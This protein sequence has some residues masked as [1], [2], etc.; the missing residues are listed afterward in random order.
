MTAAITAELRKA[1][2]AAYRRD[3]A[4]CMEDIGREA[5][6]AEYDRGEARTLALTLI[7]SVRRRRARA[8]GA[9]RLM[10]EFSP[11]TREGVALMCLAEALLRVPDAPTADRLIRDKIGYADWKSHLGNPSLFVNAATWGLMLGSKLLTADDRD[12]ERGVLGSTLGGILA[13]GGEPAVRVG[14]EFAARRL[15][16]QYVMAPTIEAA[17]V[18]AASAEARGYRYSFDVL[19]EAAM[20]AEE[21]ERYERDYAKAIE[22]VGRASRGRGVKLGPGIS[23]KLSAL[24]PRYTHRQ[25]ERVMAELLPRLVGLAR[26]AREHDVGISIDAEEADRLE[27]SLDLFAALAEE[28]SLS[29]WDGLGFVVQ[30]YQKRA[31][32]VVDWLIDLARRRKTRLM[33][34]LVKGAYWDSEIK[35][36][37]AD[38][39]SDFP[40]FTRKVHTDVV[41]LACAQR[42]LH[43]AEAVYPQFATHNAY[44]VAALAH[45]ARAARVE[46]Y[47]FQC[48]HGMGET[49][50]DEIVG[51]E[52][53]GKACRIYAPVGTHDTLLPYL[54]RRLLENGANNAFVRQLADASIPLDR[55][56]EDPLDTMR[57]EGEGPHPAILLPGQLYGPRRLNSEGVDLSDDP[58]IDRLGA[59]LM[60]L[61]AQRWIAEPLVAGMN[62]FGTEPG[63][64]GLAAGS[65]RVSQPVVNPA[66]RDD[67]V[68]RV[69]AATPEQADMAVTRAVE[70]A[71]TWWRTPVAERA[72]ALRRAADL[73]ERERDTL[74]S[75]CI[76]EAGKTWSNAI[77][78]VREAV[79]ACRY[80]AEQL[81]ES[82]DRPESTWAG[83]GEGVG[84][85]PQEGV[86]RSA[87]SGFA[88][89]EAPLPR[90]AARTVFD[91]LLTETHGSP[92]LAYPE[93]GRLP[94]GEPAPGPVVC[95]SPWNFPLAIF[96][97]QIAGALA[98]GRTVIAKPAG[99][100]PLVASFAVERLRE[101]GIPEV[102]LQF[103]PGSGASVGAPLIAD[104][105]VSGVLFTGST[106]VAR[107]IERTL[108]AR[109]GS[110]LI[111]E[112]GGQN[113]MIVDSTALPEQVVADVLASGFDSAGQRC[114]ALRV[115]CLQNDIA[116]RTLTMLRAA[117]RELA[118]GDPARLDTDVGPV[119]DAAA[120]AA[121]LAHVE[122]MRHR[123]KNVYEVDLPDACGA[124]CFVPP[125]LIEID[126]LA[127]LE[128]EVFGPIVHVLR[129]DAGRLDELI[130]AIN[131]TGYGLTLGIHSRIDETVRRISS[132]AHVGNVYVNR[133]MI[134]AVVGVQPFGGEGLSGTGPKAG[135]PLYVHRLLGS[136]NV[137]PADYGAVR[138]AD[139]LHGDTLFSRLTKWAFSSG[140]RDLVRYCTAY[141]ELTPFG[142]RVDL[143]GPTGERNT[144]TFAPRG[145][146]LCEASDAGRLLNALAAAFATGNEVAVPDNAVARSILANI[147]PRD[148]ASRIMVRTV[149]EAAGLAGVLC[150]DA[151][152]EAAW[153][154]RFA[155]E[156]GPLRPVYTPG[157]A[158][159]LY[160]LYRMMVE[161]VV[162]VNTTAS[163]GNT[164]LM[165]LGA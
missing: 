124:G 160:P 133:N 141:A 32:F 9:D 74:V 103:L 131:A 165:M 34:R 23:V 155:A 139:P 150:A 148:I 21:A 49:L 80:Y 113:A 30:A 123:G 6:A 121:L 138:E 91:E 19:G 68:G 90:N 145:R 97:A 38:G 162:S 72:A 33:V 130:D 149:E 15:A 55:L 54:V 18:R 29:G 125:T 56:V 81:I 5:M 109:P 25:H 159:G 88:R 110:C 61:A 48:L 79:D 116:E 67:T 94:S 99:Q 1:I 35:R 3:E 43:A 105:R 89:H 52:K 2:R 120:R 158:T 77:A 12:G 20:T 76:R 13:R 39:L 118:V 24:H 36:A 82:G 37:Q 41:Y 8:G 58:T 53:L 69:F 27:L 7:E 63:Q 16:Q 111:A 151:T 106:E 87:G 44:A 71:D 152:A 86:R 147:L 50:Y 14:V 85:H 119:I 64:A 143:P 101:A 92:L 153:R 46:D 98:A 83:S 117:M 28:K 156:E 100:T 132:R 135:G 78:E 129:F 128:Q 4:A 122:T 164:S 146:L 161:R 11:D 10:H 66:D 95:V 51:K 73:F 144:L 142:A 45:M 47:E 112:T 126:S 40:V 137:L 134:G 59:A 57:R 115:L 84:R 114:S 157:P 75:L 108:A 17:L 31:P 22:T 96:V 104:E 26:L 62:A 127:E 154:M 60:G 42:L 102:A 70:F 93:R 65:C 136:E 163:G 140:R 107:G